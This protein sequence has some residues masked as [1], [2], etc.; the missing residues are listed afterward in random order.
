M[1]RFV[2]F[3]IFTTG[4]KLIVKV[5][6]GRNGGRYNHILLQ[7]NISNKS[8]ELYI[9]LRSNISSLLLNKHI[10]CRY[11]LKSSIYSA[12]G[13]NIISLNCKLS[14]EKNTC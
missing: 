3:G 9:E 11:M 10:D 1:D 8:L 13:L 4:E 5:M 6:F 2:V 12:R 14:S 7:Q